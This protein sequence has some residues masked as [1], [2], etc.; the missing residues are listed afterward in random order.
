M[1]TGDAKETAVA[2]AQQVGLYGPQGVPIR[3]SA[4]SGEEIGKC[5]LKLC[6]LQKLEKTRIIPQI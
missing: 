6:F 4:I 3:N 1:L 2:I 5:F